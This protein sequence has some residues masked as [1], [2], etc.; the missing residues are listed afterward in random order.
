MALVAVTGRAGRRVFLAVRMFLV[1][2]SRLAVFLVVA[3]RAAG[4]VTRARMTGAAVVA[5]QSSTCHTSRCCSA[6]V[7]SSDGVTWSCLN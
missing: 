7:V 5:T 3:S 1:G 6:S 4:A 2:L